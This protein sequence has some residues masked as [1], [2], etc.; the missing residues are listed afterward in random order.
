MN[1]VIAEADK[2][3]G[4]RGGGKG[5]AGSSNSDCPPRKFP[6]LKGKGEKE[7]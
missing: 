1:W 5:G 6:R 7:S 2:V 3:M 4:T